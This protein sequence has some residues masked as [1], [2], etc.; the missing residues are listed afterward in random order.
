MTPWGRQWRGCFTASV[1]GYPI[2]QGWVGDRTLLP[3]ILTSLVV[4]GTPGFSAQTENAP[5][6]TEDR[7][8]APSLV[9][10]I[11][12]RSEVVK[13]AN[14]WLNQ[15]AVQWHPQSHP[16]FKS[17]LIIEKDG[18]LIRLDQDEINVFPEFPNSWLRRHRLNPLDGELPIRDLDRDG[19]SVAEEFR[20]GTDPRDS[21]SH[22]PYAEKLSFLARHATVYRIRFE[23]MPSDHRF[24]LRRLRSE[25]WEE[26]VSILAPG[27]STPDGQIRVD[28]L[29][30]KGLKLTYLPTGERFALAT[31]DSK[32][33]PTW[34]VELRLE[35]PGESTFLVKEGE[36]FRLSP[37]LGVSLRLL[38]VSAD[39]CVISTIPENDRNA[40]RWTLP[41]AK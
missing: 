9:E 19:F 2:Q 7:K 25:T 17:E 36:T 15:G 40:R 32:E 22:P 34:F 27:D 41:L 20:A 10:E 30:D 1:Q 11:R 14:D 23:A 29:G 8:S 4:I 26:K 33:I 39:D 6:Q 28:R 18:Q 24:Q 21:S 31:G 12:Q 5:S 16:L 38:A 37:E 13:Q 35:L 3:W